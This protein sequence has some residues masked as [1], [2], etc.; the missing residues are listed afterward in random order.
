LCE[1]ELAALGMSVNDK[2]TVCMRIGTRF[3]NQCANIVTSNNKELSWV[4]EVRYLGVYI[5][6]SIRFKCSFDC[7][8][9]SFF[10]CFNSIYGRG[11]GKIYEEI[12]LFLVQS[13]CMP[14]SA[15]W[16]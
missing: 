15:L 7:N 12:I 4:T 13:K 5:V 14:R 10:R 8:K 6:S 11:G 9:K 2:K 3:L 1:G 16:Y